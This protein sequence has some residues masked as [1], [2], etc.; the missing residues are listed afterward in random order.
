MLNAKS[1]KNREA[2]KIKTTAIKLVNETMLVKNRSGKK[3]RA[4]IPKNCKLYPKRKPAEVATAFPPLNFK[5]IEKACPRIAA[6]PK[7]RHSQ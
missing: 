3:I 5:K 4:Q 7:I 1:L 6:K 2:I